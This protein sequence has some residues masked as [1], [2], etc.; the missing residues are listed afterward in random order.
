[1]KDSGVEWIGEIPSHWGRKRLKHI[2]ES[3]NGYSFKSDDFDREYDIPVIRIGDVGDSIDFNNCVKVKSHFLEEKSE[4]IVK[5][6][7]ILIGLTG[8]TIGLPSIRQEIWILA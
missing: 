5:K 1:M 4:F 6:D 7:D 3:V 2:S 8:G